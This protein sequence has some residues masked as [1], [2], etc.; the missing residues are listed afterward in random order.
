MHSAKDLSFNSSKVIFP[1]SWLTVFNVIKELPSDSRGKTTWAIPLD[2]SKN[3]TICNLILQSKIVPNPIIWLTTTSNGTFTGMDDEKA[4]LLISWL[5]SH[6]FIF[7][8]QPTHG[9]ES[10]FIASVP[11]TTACGK[12]SLGSQNAF[13]CTTL[14]CI[15]CNWPTEKK[16]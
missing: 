1:T 2:S 3:I 15:I 14:W 6:C 7:P 11:L 4:Y 16:Q 12:H 13:F 8:P 10:F 5:I 9:I